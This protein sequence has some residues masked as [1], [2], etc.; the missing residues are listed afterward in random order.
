MS[1]DAIR[2]ARLR[3]ARNGARVAARVRRRE[4]VAD[5][6]RYGIGP[7]IIALSAAGWTLQRIADEMT[8]RGLRTRDYSKRWH[9]AQV[10]RIIQ[11]ALDDAPATIARLEAE[12]KALR[13]VWVRERKRRE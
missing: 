11:W 5:D 7:F 9:A 3:G 12:A 10:A 4:A 1:A 13:T 2:V 6:R 8:A